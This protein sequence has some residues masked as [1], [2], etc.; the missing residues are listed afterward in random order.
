MRKETIVKTYY[1]FDELTAEQQEKAL[2]LRREYHVDDEW[3]DGVF[4]CAKAAG[5]MM[6]IEISAIYFSG[7]WHQGDGACFVGE[8]TYEKGMVQ[9]IL[10]EYP[11][12]ED[13]HSIVREL[14]RLHAESFYSTQVNTTHR[15]HYN[16]EYSMHLDIR[17]EHG[18]ENYDA[19]KEVCADFAQWIYAYLE[20]EYEYLTSDEFLREWLSEG[21]DEFELSEVA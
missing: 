17:H 3:W 4:Y 6:G 13:L 20:K 11:K 8:I 16:H 5:K 12:A 15:G 2:D 9:K 14:Q 1:K 21:D 10:E 19:W 7:F 18:C